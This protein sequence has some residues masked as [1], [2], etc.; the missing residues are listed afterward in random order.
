MQFRR[1][2]ETEILIKLKLIDKIMLLIGQLAWGPVD[3]KLV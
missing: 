2:I 3:N 1:Q